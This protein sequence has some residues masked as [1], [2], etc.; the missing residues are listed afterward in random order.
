MRKR[1]ITWYA[2]QRTSAIQPMSIM[3]TL[4]FQLSANNLDKHSNRGLHAKT[5][6]KDIQ[7]ISAKQQ[8][9]QIA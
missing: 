7:S 2:L 8:H 9:Y 3:L 4:S 1:N 6:S 5:T